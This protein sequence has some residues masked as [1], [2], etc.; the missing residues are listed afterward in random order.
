MTSDFGRRYPKLLAPDGS[1]LHCGHAAVHHSV[2]FT[3]MVIMRGTAKAAG[4]R[5][6]PKCGCAYMTYNVGDRGA[7][8][9][10]GKD[11]YLI[12]QALPRLD[13]AIGIGDSL[14]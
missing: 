6:D 12:E 1:C 5:H 9:R 7:E 10:S 8:L 4:V 3:C 13:P 11:W 14:R 2:Q